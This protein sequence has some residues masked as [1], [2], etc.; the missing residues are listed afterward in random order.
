M[1]KQPEITAITRQN[2]IEAFWAL[3]CK[4]RIDKITIKDITTLAGY[5]R[6][7]FYEYFTDVYD[8]LEQIE[9]KLLPAADRLPISEF[10]E[11]D[12]NDDYAFNSL[13]KFYEKNSGY[14]TVLL[15]EKGDP[16]FLPKMK[17]TVSPIIKQGLIEKGATD[18]FELDVLIEYN[19]S[20]M[21]GIFDLWF[22]AADKPPIKE[23][24]KFV[25]AIKSKGETKVINELIEK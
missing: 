19:I 13:F 21:L 6:G 15:G 5:N 7:T 2:L 22:T 23:F 9:S 10:Q 17:K 4:K 14:L 1:N 25:Y 18:N 12:I 8:V 20:A 24:I 3:Y 11:N 16:S